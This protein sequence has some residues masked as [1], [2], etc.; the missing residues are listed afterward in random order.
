MCASFKDDEGH[1]LR[2]CGR[3]RWATNEIDLVGDIDKFTKLDS[4]MTFCD[5]GC[6]LRQV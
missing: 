6:E 3:L 4:L 5:P 1:L 2:L